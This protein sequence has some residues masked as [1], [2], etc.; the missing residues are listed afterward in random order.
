VIGAVVEVLS[1][2]REP[3]GWAR[4]PLAGL[5]LL[6]YLYGGAQWLRAAGYRLGWPRAYRAPCPV[7]SV[8]NL[9]A[10]GT[11]K[12][13]MVVWLAARLA[14][15][16]HRVAVV[17]RGYR[18]EG[19]RP[20]TVV[21][22]GRGH[23]LTPPAA[24]DEAA[25]VAARL[26]EVV[27]VTAPARWRAI[28]RATRELGCDC[29]VLDDA[30]QHLAVA[31]DLD[32]CLLDSDRPF[33]NG[34]VLPG[35]LLRELPAAVGRADLAVLTRAGGDGAA[36]TVA[37]LV[38]RFP[39]LPV[40]VTHHAVGAV[41]RLGGEGEG[42]DVAGSRLACLCG[43]ARP[44]GFR[45]AV[46]GLGVEVA[47]LFAFGDHHPFSAGDLRTVAEQAAA[48][49][50]TGL[51]C[52]EK[53]A[54]KI[55][56]AWSPLPI[57]VVRLELELVAGGDE[58]WRRVVEVVGPPPAASGA[59]D[60]PARPA[61][62]IDRDGTLIEERNYLADPEGVALIPGAAAA[63]AA[64]NRVGVPVVLVTNQSGIGRGY[65]GE[66][67][68]AA[69]N[70]R[71]EEL[72]AAEGAHLDGL[73]HCP[74]APDAGCNCRKPEPGMALQA[75]A[76]LHLDL[77]RSCVIG[78]K[79]VDLVLARGVGASPL[80]VRT[81]YGRETEAAGGDADRVFDDL[82]GAIRWVVAMVTAPL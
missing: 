8:G 68:L 64:A 73:Y 22:D 48:A 35:G 16:G 36:A 41:V 4:L 38:R 29:V 52:T 32:L 10:G 81:G 79:E 24:A 34:A 23:R 69:V 17:S 6:G 62:L 33:G 26:P 46:E 78:D 40:A 53:D 25:M 1:G 31:R 28:E 47:H 50:A 5:R 12:T 13:P 20:V 7:V 49:G 27:V 76:D 15:A 39:R 74:H 37:A 3:P 67:E 19:G 42:G 66:A 57:W 44:D 59:V 18:Q 72:L 77:A 45:A 70:R 43:I 58:L 65:F 75:A 56:P 80:L 71:T 54:V 30:F 51:I 14:A 2:W 9:A 21:S 11:G 82:G 60:G 55:D 63:I 61:I